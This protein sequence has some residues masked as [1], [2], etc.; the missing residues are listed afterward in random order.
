MFCR[1]TLTRGR[2]L[3]STFATRGEHTGAEGHRD[4][5][6]AVPGGQLAQDAL[7][8][9]AH[10]LHRDVEDLGYGLVL[11]A[12]RDQLKDLDRKSVV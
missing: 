6:R 12:L 11:Q 2:R 8:V 5:V 4:G 10:G 3:W 7:H 9:R 1:P